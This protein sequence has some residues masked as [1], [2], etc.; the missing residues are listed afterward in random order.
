VNIQ[1]LKQILAKLNVT[2][3]KSKG[4][5]FLL[6]M[7]IAE[8]I[9]DF[10]NIKRSETVLEI[11]PGLGSLTNFI[12]TRTDD[13]FVVEK[14]MSFADYLGEKFA[15]T[16][17][18]KQVLNQDIR[19]I[20]LESLSEQPIVVISNVPYSI[21]SEVILWT[22][23]QRLNISRAS[24]LFQK[25]FAERIAGSP[26]TKAYG[27][28]SVLCEIFFERE[29]GLIV[30]G[31]EFHPPAE[32][33]SRLI[34]LTRREKPLVEVSQWNFFEKVVRSC[35]H[36]RRKTISN[37]L[38]QAGFFDDRAQMELVLEGLNINPKARGET[39]DVYEF[40]TLSNA[41]WNRQQS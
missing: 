19:D 5:N 7:H 4:Q 31:K 18:L 14:E 35:F 6:N 41:I 32:V 33:E 20:S 21:S 39:L 40:A 22:I 12:T 28:L 24:Y 34:R 37:N 16:S 38:L 15:E 26:G 17:N 9:V 2:P 29:L 23:E 13:L 3:R 1:E 11:G 30:S 25:E 10:A 8:S 27:S 36:M